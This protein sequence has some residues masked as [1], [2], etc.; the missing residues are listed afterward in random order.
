MMRMPSQARCSLG[1]PSLVQ[2][3]LPLAL[4]ADRGVR[5]VGRLLLVAGLALGQHRGASAQPPAAVTI[6]AENVAPPNIAAQFHGGTPTRGLHG[7][8]AALPPGNTARNRLRRGGPVAGY[9]QPV[10][11]TSEQ[12]GV[13]VAMVENGDFGEP[14]PT[15]CAAGLLIGPVYRL[16]VTNI[17]NYEG[18]EVFPSI[19][20]IDRLYPPSGSERKHPIPVELTEEDL[21]LALQGHFITRV[22]YVEDPEKALPGLSHPEHPTW[23]DAGPGANPLI[24]AGQ[25]GRP[26]AILRLGGRLPDL[27]N[28]PDQQFL[29]GCPAW[30]RVGSADL[31]RPASP[32]VISDRPLQVQP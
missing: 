14:R 30:I 31:A 10:Q 25:F 11:V 2:R 28:G 32:T 5:A 19:E 20:V 6:A 22:I 12:P 17:P 15:P 26:V 27:S 21:Q 23:F 24:E 9:F 13:S 29:G 16:R 7:P 3:W 8:S 1:R 18:R 4:V